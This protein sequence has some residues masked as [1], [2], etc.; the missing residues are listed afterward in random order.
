MYGIHHTGF[1][2]PNLEE[3]LAFYCDTLGGEMI[4]EIAVAM[5]AGMGLGKIASVIHPY[6]TQA[7]IIR[8]LGDEYNRTR[9]TPFV[10]K[11][12]RK[13]MAWQR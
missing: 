11:V 4:G 1:S 3:A 5:A 9:L 6:P 8:K 12:F 2:V 7:E 10:A 13:I